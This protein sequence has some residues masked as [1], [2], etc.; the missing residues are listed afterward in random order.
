VLG[1]LIIVFREVFE[2]GLIIGIVLAVTQTVVGRAWWIGGGVLAGVAGACVVA[3]FAN[4]LSAA[5]GGI[6]QELFNACILAI[7]AVMLT[8]H[9]VWMSWHGRALAGEMRA[10]G[11]AVAAGSKSLL[12]MAVVVSVAVLRE[13]VEV[14]LFLYGVVISGGESG[15][16]IFTGGVAGLML[17]VLVCLLM[18][19]GLLTIPS[20]HLFTVTGLM[21]AFLAAGMAA[22]AVGFL[23]QANLVT[24]LDTIVW[25]TSWLLSEKSIVGRALHTL[26]GYNDQPT[27]MQLMVYLMTLAGMYLLMKLYSAAP[28]WR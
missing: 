27:L 21:I 17:G 22:Q 14:V 20:H 7:A 15:A 4:V 18:Y 23:Q 28:S 13:G 8:W 12:G 6:G 5:F 9:N 1:A 2:A 19:Y 25:N 11:Q 10:V 3:V 16:A 26:I 24:A